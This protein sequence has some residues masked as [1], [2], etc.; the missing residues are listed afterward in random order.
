M[1]VEQVYQDFLNRAP[2]A[3]GLTYWAD[4][5]KSGALDRSELVEQYLNSG[6]F[7]FDKA[8]IFL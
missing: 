5:L 4:Q 2:D 8:I 1:F 7:D 3:E 6:E